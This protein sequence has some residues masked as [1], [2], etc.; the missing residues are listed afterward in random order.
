MQNYKTQGL[1]T[2]FCE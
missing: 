2:N 1:W